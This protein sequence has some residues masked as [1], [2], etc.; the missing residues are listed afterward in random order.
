MALRHLEL[1]DFR[2]FPAAQLDPE[3]EGHGPPQDTR[4]GI[5]R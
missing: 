5:R 2:L 1:T 4:T 3:P